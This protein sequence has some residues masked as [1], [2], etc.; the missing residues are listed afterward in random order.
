M[1]VLPLGL[2]AVVVLTLWVLAARNA[3][4]LHELA[5]HRE[6]LRAW[7]SAHLWKALA[8]YV[9]LYA[10]LVAASVPVAALLSITGGFL[11]GWLTGASTA[12]I[13]ATS[14]AVLIFLLARGT[15]A[16]PLARR[17]GPRL[18]TLRCHFH[19]NA[20]SYVLFMRLMPVFPFWLVNLASALFGVKLRHFVLATVIGGIPAAL[21]FAL[22]GSGL[23]EILA[24]QYRAYQLC[25]QESPGAATCRISLD[26]SSLLTP[27][28]L[29]AFAVLGV[30][31]LVPAMVKRLV[32]GGIV[33][34]PE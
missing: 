32:V 18:E 12:V 22:A 7:V 3:W 11:F 24:A 10:V 28:L 13:G 9:L 25:L 4:T 2:L 14:G 21:A 23:D 20:F 26:P 5:E 19:E 30:I 29:I 33:S 1:R 8:T 6:P 27:E 15:L 17:C 16:A 34:R 31:A